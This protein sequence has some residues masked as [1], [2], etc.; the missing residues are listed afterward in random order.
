MSEVQPDHPNA[1]EQARSLLYREFATAE[2][3]SAMAHCHHCVSP[4]DL[5]AL[6]APVEMLDAGLVARFVTKSG[7]TW[8]TSDDLRRVVPR[9]LELSADAA[10]PIHR[11]VL[12]EKLASTG[13]AD[14][15]APQVTAICRFLLAEWARLLLSTPRPGHAAHRWLR[16]TAR[17]VDDLKPFLTAWQTAMGSQV[18]ASGRRAAAVHLAV[19]L[20]N[21]EFRPDFPESI[22]LLFDEAASGGSTDVAGAVPAAQLEGWLLSTATESQLSQAADALANT[23]DSRRQTPY[24]PSPSTMS[25]ADRLTPEA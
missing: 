10:L 14:W 8:G 2:F 1:F 24:R 21:S 6:G 18:P 7:T 15:P 25:A 13:W 3:N 5:V 4:D 16:Q 17:A 9:A 23:S 11:A 19:L 20:V 22:T 12:L